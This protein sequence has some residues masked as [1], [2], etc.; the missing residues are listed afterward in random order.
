[1]NQRGRSSARKSSAPLPGLGRN[2]RRGGAAK[3]MGNPARGAVGVLARCFLLTPFRAPATSER[4]NLVLWALLLTLLLPMAPGCSGCRDSSSSSQSPPGK[5]KE[6]RKREEEQK[7]KDKPK[8][9][10]DFEK[11]KLTALPHDGQDLTQGVKPSHWVSATLDAKANNFDFSGDLEV[12]ILTGAGSPVDLERTS[13]RLLTT[14]PA[15]LPKGQ[16]K[17]LE[18]LFF[19]PRSL[20]TTVATRLFGRGGGGE[21]L[22]DRQPVS[23]LP[24]YQYFMYV[25]SSQP[26]RYRYLKVL[27]SIKPPHDDLAE[28]ER[29]VYYRVQLPRVGQTVSLP[30][31]P[32]VWTSTA[33]LLWD[34]IHPK[35]LRNDQQ[36]AMLDWLHWGGQILVSGP[37]TL[38]LLRGSF[39]EP[40]LPAT[41]GPS[42]QLDEGALD[43]LNR[44]WT[45]PTTRGLGLPLEITQPWTAVKLVRHENASYLPGTGELLVE[46]RV[47]RGRIVVSAFRLTERD[48]TSWR[49]YDS[50]FNNALLRHPPRIY[51]EGDLA[52][53]TVDWIDPK[54]RAPLK[55]LR[56]DPSIICD[57][58]YFSRDGGSPEEQQA[59]QEKAGL[60]AD[61]AEQL[62]SDP[63]FVSPAAGVGLPGGPTEMQIYVDSKRIAYAEHQPGVAGW[64]DFS[65]V[66]HAARES[67]RA[68]AGIVV[69][70]RRFVVWV[71]GLYLVVIVPLNWLVFWALGR[72]EWAWI[73]APVIAVACALSVVKMAQLDIG[74]ARSRTEVAVVE[75]QGNYPRAHVTR[76]TALYTSLSTG[77]DVHFDDPSALAAPLS[78]DPGF[79]L[80]TGQASRNVLFRRDNAVHLTGYQ[81]L[82][83]STGML[84]TEQMLDLGG[85]LELV[86]PDDLVP[87]VVNGTELLLQG[88]LVMRRAKSGAEYAWIGVLR[89]RQAAALDFRPAAGQPPRREQSPITADNPPLG[90]ISLKSLVRLAEETHDLHE[91]DVRLVAW[92]EHEMPGMLIKPRSSQQRHATLVVANLRRALGPTPTKDANT[93]SELAKPDDD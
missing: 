10:P 37:R 68:A 11:L 84:H 61:I 50:F 31:H 75:L 85:G 28:K 6:N 70:H 56:F 46:R 41:G 34:D 87:R 82:S 63:A 60:P 66:A 52:T 65:P 23:H 8:P 15:T 3:A 57:L 2:V 51:H 14:R 83:N 5:D 73:A 35:V 29:D 43:E 24:A 42:I 1:M 88:A 4:N 64:C 47:G 72:V 27:D 81:I 93:R 12:G 74:F 13:Y 92:N 21:V 71:V 19:V 44:S 89:P 79:R 39:L 55:D 53:T 32:L 77:Y 40:Y 25:L 18:L 9:K 7:K 78:T 38:D 76:F 22:Q 17:R 90:T 33:V 69:P 67:L 86:N 58:R 30:S 62:L 26:D 54:T 48:L 45:V 59:T 20:S 16:A 91:G 80:L 49:S 36:Q